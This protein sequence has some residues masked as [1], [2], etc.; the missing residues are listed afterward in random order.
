L[1]NDLK[2]IGLTLDEEDKLANS[3]SRWCQRVA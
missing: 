2:D 1:Q 3:K